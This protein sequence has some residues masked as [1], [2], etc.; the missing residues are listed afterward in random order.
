MTKLITVLYAYEPGLI[1]RLLGAV[2]EAAHAYSLGPPLRKQ[3]LEG[4]LIFLLLSCGGGIYL[5]RLPI[6]Y[7]N[8]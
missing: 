4:V 7:T 1:A 8:Y 3:D 2:L 5:F 6:D